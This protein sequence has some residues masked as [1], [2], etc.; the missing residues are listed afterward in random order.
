MK[1]AYSHSSFRETPI[2][3]HVCIAC[4]L[5]DKI[6]RKLAKTHLSL[7]ISTLLLGCKIEGNLTLLCC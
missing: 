4:N 7:R 1:V 3:V 2:K 5:L 6:C